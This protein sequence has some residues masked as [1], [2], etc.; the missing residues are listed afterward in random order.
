MSAVVIPEV[1]QRLSGSQS[2]AI[3][4]V[5]GSRTCAVAHSGMTE[6]RRPALDK[7]ARGP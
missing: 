3:A 5:G 6:L 2:R 1:A 4:F 7:Q